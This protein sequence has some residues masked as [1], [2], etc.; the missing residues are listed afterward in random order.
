MARST[1]TLYDQVVDVAA[2]FLGPAAERFIDRQIS[3]HLD[4]SPEQLTRADILPLTDW[5]QIAVS[6]ITE[7]H[8]IVEEFTSR[9]SALSKK[10]G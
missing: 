3:N 9:L 8:S 5:V 1:P 4:K 10:A 7:D 2:D 6:L